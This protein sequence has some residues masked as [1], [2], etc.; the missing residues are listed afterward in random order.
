MLYSI[1]SEKQPSS[2]RKTLLM[3]GR[4]METTTQGEW[5]QITSKFN[6]TCRN[7][8]V[9]INAGEE[10]LWKPGI[11]I[12]VQCAATMPKEEE[13]KAQP[14]VKDLP[15]IPDGTYTIVH[16]DGTH[17]T[18]KFSVPTKGTFEGR[19]I[20]SFLSGSDNESSYTGFAFVLPNNELKTWNRF[21]HYACAEK[22]KS[23]IRILY[24]AVKNEGNEAI[25]Q[26]GE[27]YAMQSG[28]CCKCN[29][30]LTVPSSIHRGMGKKCSEMNW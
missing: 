8:E 26:A 15:R 17:T 30:K 4:P 5:K 22:V 12:H 10:I 6:A 20:V 16:E 24:K 18:V 19:R 11:A 3:K 14:K 25:M 23:A 1:V 13:F 27:A 29:R 28:K 21:Q 2:K 7:C 9:T